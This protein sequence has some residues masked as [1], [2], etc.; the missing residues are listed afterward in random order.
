MGQY[1]DANEDELLASRFVTFE[2]ETLQN[3]EALVPVLLYLFHR[4]DQRLDSRPTLLVIDEAA[5]GTL[6]WEYMQ[7][8]NGGVRWGDSTMGFPD[9]VPFDRDRKLY[10]TMKVDV[11]NT[12]L[13]QRATLDLVQKDVLAWRDQA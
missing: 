8:T 3:N 13:E 6:F 9:W 1:I 10:G 4:I 7:T 11:T 2:L 12:Q 5:W